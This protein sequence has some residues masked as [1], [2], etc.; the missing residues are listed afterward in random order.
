MDFSKLFQYVPDNLVVIT[1]DFK[2]VAAT[3]AYLRT[4]MRQ[5]DDLRGLHFLLEAF[6]DK[7]YT[8]EENPVRKSIDKVLQTKQVDYMDLVRYTIARPAAEGGGEY[9][10]IWE[11]SHTPVLD[12]QGN[13]EFIIQKTMDVTEREQAKLAHQESENKFRIMTDAVPQL[14]YTVHPEGRVTFVNERFVKYTGTPAEEILASPTGFLN[15]IHPDDQ[16]TFL[17]KAQESFQSQVEFQ[18]EIRLRDREGNY[19]WFVK[20]CSPVA[21]TAGKVS[22]WVGS[23][24][25]IQATKQMVQELLESNEQMAYLSDQVHAALQ[26][27]E[28]ERK[29]LENMIMNAPAIFCTLTGP[30]HRFDLINPYYQALFP[31]R[32]LKGKTVKKAVPEAAEQ[33]FVDLLNNV[34]QTGTPFSADEV[35]F[36]RKRQDTGAVED[37][38]LTL[39]YQPIYGENMKTIGVLVFGYETTEHVKLRER[40]QQKEKG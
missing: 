4:T 39:N 11:A 15:A 8:F 23:A 38:Y 1:P 28:S 20:K 37:V 16:E 9:E 32:E 36:Q 14:I 30:E 26:K 33:G 27:A 35:H 34:Y 7:N 22:L 5:I 19:R 24:T 18:A 29:T 17:A 3:E 31:D 40:F 6:P 2:I 13:I 10:S 25:D 12:P 21:L